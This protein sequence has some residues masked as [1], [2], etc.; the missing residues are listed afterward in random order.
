M[1]SLCCKNKKNQKKIKW[2][3][4]AAYIHEEEMK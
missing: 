1:I 2:I 4:L 3:A